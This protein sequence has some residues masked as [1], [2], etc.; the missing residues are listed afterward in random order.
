M[1]AGVFAMARFLLLTWA[2]FAVGFVFVLE[3]SG[4]QQEKS[5]PADKGKA[6]DILVNPGSEAAAI[7]Y[8]KD[9]VTPETGFPTDPRPHLD[10]LLKHFGYDESS[11]KLESEDPALIM[12]RL[13]TEVLASRFFAPKITDVSTVSSKIGWRKLVRF[14]ARSGS[15]AEKKGLKSV[16][17]LFN[18]F[19]D[20]ANPSPFIL[21]NGSVNHSVNNQVIMV[22]KEGVALQSAY[23]MTFAPIDPTKPSESGRLITYLDATFDA[24]DPDQKLQRYY[25][26]IACAECHGGSRRGKLNYLDTDHWFDRVN[27]DDFDAV[28]K[29]HALL[30]DAGT[31]ESTTVEFKKSFDVIRLIN[32]DIEEQNRDADGTTVGFQQKA[33]A[34]WIRHHSTTENQ[35]PLLQR[36]LDEN[37]SEKWSANNETDAKLLPLLNRYCFRCHSSIRFHIYQKASVLELK[38]R[39][40]TRLSSE[41][42]GFFMPQDRKLP[43]SVKNEIIQLLNDLK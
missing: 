28:G 25:V 39:M 24:G 8:Y 10:D 23:Y 9:K 43:D 27:N 3:S 32:K 30:F 5:S 14:R 18:F 6:F 11:E 4:Q 31:N 22:R 29:Q 20:N 17:I 38:Q 33:A 42:A 34:A 35:I 7:A 26:P 1:N 15:E 2:F 36:S 41:E 16:F 37:D 40:I 19:S 21:P 13:P 12:G